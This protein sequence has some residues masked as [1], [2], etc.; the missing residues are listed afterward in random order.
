M[1]MKVPADYTATAIGRATR[2]DASSCHSI[3]CSAMQPI[4]SRSS[5]FAIAR[6]Q[7]SSCRYG[8]SEAHY[9]CLAVTR[10]YDPE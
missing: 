6:T 3:P 1:P 9:K 8:F 5:S 4:R 2:L 7:K 10:I